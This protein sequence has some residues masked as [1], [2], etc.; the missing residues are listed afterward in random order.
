MKKIL[1]GFLLLGIVF[2]ALGQKREPVKD[3]Q[4]VPKRKLIIF[5]TEKKPFLICKYNFDLKLQRYSPSKNFNDYK[6]KNL[7]IF[8][9]KKTRANI[10]I[11][12]LYPVFNL[13]ELAEKEKFECIFLLPLSRYKQF[14]Q[15]SED[16]NI[17]VTASISG[18]RFIRDDEEVNIEFSADAS[19]AEKLQALWKRGMK[20]KLK[21]N[22]SEYEDTEFET[23]LYM[24][25]F[26]SV[27]TDKPNNWKKNDLAKLIFTF[28]G[29]NDIRDA[30][31]MDK[32]GEPIM[33]PYDQEAPEPLTLP[34]V[35][36]T[37]TDINPGLAK[38]VP[39]SCYFIEW[40]SFANFNT[41]LYG[42]ADAFDKWSP[43]TYPLSG[44]QIIDKYIKEA[45]LKDNK[46]F[47]DNI[48]SIALAGW[49]FYFQS[50]TSFLLV[51]KTKKASGKL[52]EA[53]FVSSPEKNIVVLATSEKLYKMALS[54]YGKKRSLS[55]LNNFAYSRKRLSVSENENEL[56]FLYLS[57]YW[58]TNFISPRWLILTNRL[59]ELDARLRFVNL[60]RI[61]RMLETAS[62]KLPELKD[63]KSCPFLSDD[64]KKWLFSG[65]IEDSG[66]IKDEKLG[67]LYD[68]PSVDSIHFDKV[69]K[70]EASRYNN[71]KRL[72]TGRW[73]QIDPI[74]LQLVKNKAGVFKTRLY[75][76]PISRRSEFRGIRNFAPK[77][78]VKHAIKK[79][80]GTAL[81]ISVAVATPALKPFLRNITLPV[82]MFVQLTSFDFAPSS[83]SPAYWLDPERVYDSIS[84]LR[85]PA[86]V[87]LPSLAFNALIGMAGRMDIVPSDYEQINKV[88]ELERDGMNLMILE[89]KNEGLHYLGA[90]PSTLI[91]IRD[92]SSKEYINDSIPCDIRIYLNL[93]NAYQLR[94]KLWFEA[95]KNRGIA[96]WRRNNRIFRI[97]QFLGSISEN[98]K[99][100]S[101][102]DN[103]KSL[104]I[105][106]TKNIV[107]VYAMPKVRNVPL[108]ARRGYTSS[109]LS[110]L[111]KLPEVLLKITQIDSFISVEEN[112][113]LF[114]THFRLFKETEIREKPKAQALKEPQQQG[115]TSLDFDE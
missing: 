115:S 48:E 61:C 4:K 31:P 57:D 10:S 3:K 7:N 97:Q 89:K 29:L 67:A 56:A 18:D 42:I 39:R 21:A 36:V 88:S 30:V 41:T 28:S 45:G 27:P 6:I 65:L 107:K 19:Q 103:I 86:A 53:P 100:N 73:K 114:E 38:W 60:L 106:P 93:I 90:D 52:P 15:Y 79:I 112:A 72:Y 78:K 40:K 111:K 104:N 32:N 17:N 16:A 55:Q 83:Y 70:E 98:A 26:D 105:F 20:L 85:I 110:H 2:C 9:K 51:V 101:V 108:S 82:N 81:T 68:H 46:E 25:L 113:L 102:A 5:K 77:S 11:S 44:R 64:M 62:D 95:I 43:G 74:A 33:E 58:L 24:R 99:N 47:A 87:S 109:V 76:S 84:F 59:S 14:K 8:L 71:F 54:A 75:V 23:F 1:T 63:I 22:L 92:N 37:E 94:R 66:V 80:D 35:N 12:P 69:S 96:T 13:N 49:D 91:R 34:Q 50:G